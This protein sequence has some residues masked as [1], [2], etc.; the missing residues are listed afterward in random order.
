MGRQSIFIFIILLLFCGNVSAQQYKMRYNAYTHKQDWIFNVD[1]AYEYRAAYSEADLL[2]YEGW[3]EWGGDDAETASLIWRVSKNIY[4]GTNLTHTQFA[5]E[6]DFEYAWDSR[7]TY[8]DS[9]A[10]QYLKIDGTYYLLIDAT[11]KLRIQ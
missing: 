8:F 11:H 1:Q 9:G 4:D 5:G 10:A 6:G 2:I 3:T 7:T